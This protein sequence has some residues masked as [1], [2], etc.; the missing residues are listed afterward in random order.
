MK[1]IWLSPSDLSYFWSDSKVG[2][3]DKYVLEI[4]RPRQS[5]PSIFNHIDLMMKNAFDNKRT[6]D[7]VTGAPDGIL[8]HD[9]ISVQS[10]PISIGDYKVGF[11]GKMDCLLMHDDGTCSVI[12]YKCTHIS[13]YLK[14]IYFLQLASYALCLESPLYGEPKKVKNLG[15]IGF[16]PTD[17]SFTQSKGSLE[18]SLAWAEIPFDKNRYK[19]WLAEELKP[20]LH[21]KREDIYESSID[22]D[23][24]RYVNCFY[25]E[26][27]EE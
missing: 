9:D 10:K 8:T 7:I 23:W 14:S 22:K 6:L 26:D 16:E 15:I 12:D 11:K 18:G 1:T 13:D 19:H 3:Y 20:L 21:S 17:F 5:F 27:V 24:A 4:N 2:F 25:L